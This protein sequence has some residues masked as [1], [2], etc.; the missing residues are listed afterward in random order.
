MAKFPEYSTLGWANPLV[1]DI[2]TK[3]LISRFED[4]GDE[5]RKQKKLYPTRNVALSYKNLSRVNG[6]VIWQFFMDRGGSYEAFNFFLNYSD[7]YEGEYISTGNASETTYNLPSK[8]SSLRTIYL[9]GVAQETPT[10]YTIT[11]GAGEDG[12]DRLVF[13]AAPARGVRI[14]YDFTGKLKIRCRFIDDVFS[15]EQLYNRILNTGVTFKGLLNTSVLTWVTTTTTTTTTSSSTSSTASTTSSTSS[16]ASSTSTTSTASTTSST[17]STTSTS[18]TV[19]TTSSTVSTT[20]TTSTASTTSST[21]S[22][23]SSSST[24][25]TVSTTSSTVS[26]TSSTSSTAS[27]TTSSSTSSTISTTSSTSTTVTV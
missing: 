10:D 11:D 15:F 20:S 24:T 1:I 26:T 18:S 14:T 9:D 19:S 2:L 21:A 5:K 12:A 4:L 23:T 27:T 22:T 6:R 13:V 16:T 3:T 25:S 8:S 7:A 17:A